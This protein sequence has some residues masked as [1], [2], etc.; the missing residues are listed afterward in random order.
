MKPNLERPAPL[1]WR[2]LPTKVTCT[3][4]P[5][6]TLPPLSPRRNLPRFCCLPSPPCAARLRCHATLLPPEKKNQKLGHESDSSESS[7]DISTASQPPFSSA[8]QDC[9]FVL[10]LDF[11]KR[12]RV[13]YNHFLISWSRNDFYLLQISTNWVLTS[14]ADT[15][16]V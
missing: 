9:Y 11:L 8:L 14:T 6:G 13:F 2:N 7:T 3:F 15:H 1:L 4:I 16:L 5:Q 10:P 12:S